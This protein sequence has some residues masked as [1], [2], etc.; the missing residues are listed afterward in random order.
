MLAALKEQI[1]LL[2]LRVKRQLHHRARRSMR[3]VQSPAAVRGASDPCSYDALI[4][5]I[6]AAGTNSLRHFR[7][8]YAHE[9]GLRL[10]QNPFEFA[11]LISFLKRR[12]TIRRYFEIGSASGGASR[13]MA[14]RLHFGEFTSM[15]DGQH[16]DAHLQKVNF[17]GVVNFRQFLGD[18]HSSAAKTFMKTAFPANDI[19]VAFIDG[20]H[21]AEGVTQDLE[22]VLPYCRSGAWVVFHDTVACDGVEC[23]WLK[24]IESGCL[25]PVAEFIGGSVPL[26]IA[27]GA[28]R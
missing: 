15:D 11:S 1:R 4:A 12:G 7:N 18:S 28:V 19:D 23:A 25:I 27:I 17:A 9:G 14:E 26:G 21:S 8:G 5:E 10:Q 16:P 22:L 2:P 3:W 20:D 6:R 24:A 13:F